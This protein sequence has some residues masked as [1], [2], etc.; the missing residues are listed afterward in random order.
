MVVPEPGFEK[1]SFD[2]LPKVDA[3]MVNDFFLDFFSAEA[4]NAKTT[5]AQK[6]SFGDNAVGYVQVKKE[7]H[8]C[9]ILA[10]ITPEHKVRQKEYS[11]EA[12]VDMT[13][14][15][16]VMTVLCREAE[17]YTRAQSK[18]TEWYELRFARITAS[19]IYEAS[20]CKT[21]EGSLVEAILGGAKHIETDAIKRGLLLESEV[22]FQMEKQRNIKI[23]SRGFVLNGDYPFLGASPDGISSDYYI[24]VKC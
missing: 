3:E 21:K 24:E 8:L 16:S 15:K 10:I 18:S 19:K 13:E 5:R 4:K 11:I 22:I 20:R 23:N 17:K 7:N 1:A 9:I 14:E 12:V 2:N 6:A